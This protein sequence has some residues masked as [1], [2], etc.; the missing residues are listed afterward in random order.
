MSR[1]GLAVRFP[2]VARSGR[3]SGFHGARQGL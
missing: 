3:P 2:V 1:A